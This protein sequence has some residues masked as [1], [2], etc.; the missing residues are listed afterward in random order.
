MSRKKIKKPEQ[1][2]APEMENEVVLEPET[3][4]PQAEETETLDAALLQKQLA[5]AE[6]Q[7]EEYLNLAQRVQADF[8]N[9]RRRN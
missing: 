7:K 4:E 6:A 9:F 1:T 5:D 2:E 3:A 8:D